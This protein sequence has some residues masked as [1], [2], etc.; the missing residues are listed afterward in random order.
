MHSKGAF[1]A[2]VDR[3]ELLLPGW[4]PHHPRMFRAA[5]KDPIA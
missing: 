3:L 5:G 2:V 1:L 4:L